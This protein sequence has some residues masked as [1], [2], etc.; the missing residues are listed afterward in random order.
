MSE[1]ETAVELIEKTSLTV[2]QLA[3][4]IV[5]DLP[6]KAVRDI[7]TGA[8]EEDLGSLSNEEFSEAWQLEF[9]NPSRILDLPDY[10]N[11][12]TFA[13]EFGDGE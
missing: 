13:G 5:D 10:P 1:T 11:K 8:V 3:S 7:V 12:G 9:K 4:K 2:S 6:L